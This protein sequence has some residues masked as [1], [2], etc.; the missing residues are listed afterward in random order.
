MLLRFIDG[1]AWNNGQRLDEAKQFQLVPASGKLLQK[2]YLS[3]VKMVAHFRTALGAVV[4]W[5]E[6]SHGKQ[7]KLGS[8]I[9]LQPIFFSPWVQ[10]RRENWDYAYVML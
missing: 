4:K 7:Q 2:N 9:A 8:I 1:T 10:R 6:W 5:L 3:I